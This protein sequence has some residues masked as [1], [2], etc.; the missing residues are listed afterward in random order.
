MLT[1]AL[2][3]TLAA[4]PEGAC[5]WKDPKNPG[6]TE[7]YMDHSVVFTTAS[8]AKW[9]QCAKKAGGTLELVWS[10]GTGGELA[11]QPAVP[12]KSYSTREQ[13]KDLCATPGLKQVQ[14]QITGTGEMAK[15]NWSSGIV[16]LY[17]PKCQ[18]S[19]DDNSMAM[20]TSPR[21]DNKT[22]KGTWTMEAKFDA[23]WWACAKPGNELELQFFTGETMDEVKAATKPSHIVKGLGG[24]K[25][26][27][28]FP[29]AAICKDRPK[30]IGHHFSGAGEFRVLEG[31]T[32]Q[33][34]AVVDTYGKSIC[35]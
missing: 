23:K 30:F 16:E 34:R 15:L 11:P 28:T 29:V 3:L 9:F 6:K 12:L 35:P 13:T 10:V 33:N 1:L 2:A 4:E 14:A 31:R 24:P 25:V 7:I 32:R 8:D 17:C 21:L 19:G 27:K 26:D 5:P 20:F 22:P 18:W